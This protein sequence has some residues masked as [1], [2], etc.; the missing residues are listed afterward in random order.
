MLDFIRRPRVSSS[1]NL[2]VWCVALYLI[3]CPVMSFITG[4]HIT[5]V[6]LLKIAFKNYLLGAMCVMAFIVI[7]TVIAVLSLIFEL[8]KHLKGRCST[9]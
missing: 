8:Y 3:T 6:L 1:L 2:L 4:K 7:G 5:L 9:K